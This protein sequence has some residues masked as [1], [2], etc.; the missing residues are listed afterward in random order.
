[1]SSERTRNRERQCEQNALTRSY[2]AAS[3]PRTRVAST[4]SPDQPQAPQKQTN[5]R[6]GP[7]QYSQTRPCPPSVS[8]KAAAHPGQYRGASRRC[9]SASKGNQPRPTSPPAVTPLPGRAPERGPL[10]ELDGEGPARV[11]LVLL[12]RQVDPVAEVPVYPERVLAA[13]NARHLLLE[14]PPQHRHA[15]VRTPQVLHGPVG[16]RALG[17]PRHHVL[18]LDVVHPVPPVLVEHRDLV[19]RHRGLIRVLHADRR[20]HR[21]QHEP[22]G[23]PVDR[24]PDLH[25]LDVRP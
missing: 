11:E 18:A 24:H 8:D 15:H 9:R 16:D 12:A 14:H 20:V 23:G 25:L 5:T 21:V 1:G 22:G 19:I 10:D 7:A 3:W 6:S 13:R 4:M 17:D 2:S